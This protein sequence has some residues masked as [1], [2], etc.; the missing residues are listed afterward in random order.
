MGWVKA[1]VGIPGNKKADDLAKEG[2]DE[3]FPEESQITEGGLRQEW[4]RKREAER[5]VVGAGRGRVI[6][7][8]RKARINYVHFRTGKGNL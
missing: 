3:L 2:T 5:K 7:W 8:K 4:H 6:S 1:H